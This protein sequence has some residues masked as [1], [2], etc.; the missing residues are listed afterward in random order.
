MAG[1]KPDSWI[2][3]M[4]QYQKMIKPFSERVDGPG[5]ISFGLQPCGYD[6]RL[7]PEMRVYDSAR[8]R[9]EGLDPLNVKPEF[10]VQVRAEPFFLIPPRGFVEAMTI[11][12]FCM[13]PDCTARGVGKTTYSR[14]GISLNISSINPGWSGRLRLHISNIS[15][16][17]VRL[18]GDMGIVYLEFS[19]IDGC[20]EK[21][22]DQLANPRFQNQDRLV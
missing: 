13:P 17:P 3:R 15:P 5:V 2:R 8:A 16:V 19:E 21:S 10:F 9:G 14:V 4:A 20:P 1:I 6:A 11:E 22:Y 18:Y 12:T 7:D